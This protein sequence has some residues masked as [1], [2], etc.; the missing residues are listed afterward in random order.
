MEKKSM[1]SL[2]AAQTQCAK[3]RAASVREVG[4][5]ASAIEKKIVGSLRL[6]YAALAQGFL[7]DKVDPQA[8]VLRIN[9]TGEHEV[10][11]GDRP[12]PVSGP[13]VR[14]LF[15]E[16][17]L[18][19]R[20]GQVIL[21]EAGLVRDLLEEALARVAHDQATADRERAAL[22]TVFG[23]CRQFESEF[24]EK[25]FEDAVKRAFEDAS[26]KGEEARRRKVALLAADFALD[27]HLEQKGRSRAA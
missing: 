21:L 13:Y 9:R 16:A 3:S 25:V 24:P 14:V 6:T 1:L 2:L 20:P 22:E 26:E 8:Y 4:Q 10:K 11:L 12:V 15:K 23:R 18:A 7:P 19:L 5:D 27:E 17:G